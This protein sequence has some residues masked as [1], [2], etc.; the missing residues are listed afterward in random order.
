MEG[1]A[2]YRRP[3]LMEGMIII[4]LVEVLLGFREG[5]WEW[6]V[7]NAG[8]VKAYIYIHASCLQ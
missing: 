4:G 8:R 6:G 1:P 7:G 2:E 5:E 3:V